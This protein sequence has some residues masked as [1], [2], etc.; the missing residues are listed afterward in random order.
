MLEMLQ[1][2]TTIQAVGYASDLAAANRGASKGPLVLQKSPFISVPKVELQWQKIIFPNLPLQDILPSVVELNQELAQYTASFVKNNKFFTIL[3]GDHSSAIGTWSGAKQGLGENALGLIWI[4]AHMDSHT[5]TTTLSGNIHGMPLACLLGLGDPALIHITSPAV[6]LRP[7]NL[8]LIG[9][10]SYEQGEA[11][12][13]K[14]LNVKVFFMDEV[15]QR[16][17]NAVMK[18]ALAIVTQRTAGFGISIDI[19]AL[20]P[21]EAPGTGV[22]E[23]GGILPDEL[24]QSLKWLS[25]YQKQ[26]IGAEIAEFDPS[27]DQ[28]HKTEIVIGKLL[29]AIVSGKF[30]D[31]TYS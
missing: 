30:H 31:A 17:M 21:S 5:P 26:F 1:Y 24:C 29:K 23:P 11:E 4:D 27:R 9:V 12:L 28:E 10:R 16:G 7:E 22:P 25:V 13:L 18:E 8:C 2:M 19:D 3:G 6:K 20:E 14:K 15:K